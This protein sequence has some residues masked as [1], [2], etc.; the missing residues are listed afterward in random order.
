MQFVTAP[1]S[2]GVEIHADAPDLAY[3]RSAL[4]RAGRELDADVLAVEVLSGGRSGQPVF[5]LRALRDGQPTRS[6]VLKTISEDSARPRA[7]GVGCIEANLWRAGIMQAL[8]APLSCPSLDLAFNAAT[9]R[10]WLLMDDVS[11]GVM[12]R[13]VYDEGRLALMM[14][15]IA[16]MHARYWERA[17]Q[18]ANVVATLERTTAKFTVPVLLSARQRR[19][20]DWAQSILDETPLIGAFLPR[21]LDVLGP[22]DAD[23]YLELCEHRSRWVAALDALPKTLTQG[24]L[25]RANVAVFADRVSLFDWDVAA[26][27]PGAC[28]LQWFWFLQFWAYPPSDGKPAEDRAPLLAVYL[29]TLDAALEGGVDRTLFRKS[30]DLAWVRVFAELGFCLADSLAGDH[31]PEDR[32]RVS[33]TCKRAVAVARRACDDHA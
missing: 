23:F 15:A 20:P 10:W 21:F 1:P 17:D 14:R 16:A 5:A 9:R 11:A 4:A 32:A 25:R 8:P 2:A 29:D 18:L 12:A 3:L 24:D 31:T 19:A 26:Y 33:A 6:C 13:G 30:W 22:Q 7:L 27:A 28:D